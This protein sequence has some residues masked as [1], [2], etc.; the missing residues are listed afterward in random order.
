[1]NTELS[2]LQFQFASAQD[3]IPQQD[4]VFNLG[5]GFLLKE[6]SKCK[7]KKSIESFPKCTEN[8]NGLFSWCKKCKSEY[9]KQ[10]N[11]NHPELL[12]KEREQARKRRLANRKRYAEYSKKWQHKNPK[13]CRE[14]G[15]K[16]RL[17]N[18]VKHRE[19]IKAWALKNP[20][21]IKKMRQRGG[22]K[23]RSTI[24]GNLSCK[25]GT[26]TWKSLHKNKA[27]KSWK[28]YVSYTIEDLRKHLESKFTEGMT[29]N[30]MGKWHID[31]KVPV[32]FFQYE[33]P[34]DQE[35]Q[36]CWSLD[37]LQPLWALDNIK[38]GAKLLKTRNGKATG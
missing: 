3:V 31:H 13:K 33:K 10:Q 7:I 21:K 30:N 1:M 28:S 36:Y 27:S 15:K 25:M 5:G 32:S 20:D 22:L 24:K 38:K 35:F 18:S 16:W 2:Q 17:K 8:K 9:R 26:Q 29:W 19:L 34:S 23:F 4:S 12:I 11:F 14:Q 37:N 6:C